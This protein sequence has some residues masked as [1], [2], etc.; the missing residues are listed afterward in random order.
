MGYRGLG[1]E[2]W[3]LELGGERLVRCGSRPVRERSGV[4]DVRGRIWTR[5]VGPPDASRGPGEW[6]WGSTVVTGR[7]SKV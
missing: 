3:D 5:V 1:R 6:G 2:G 7:E 4:T